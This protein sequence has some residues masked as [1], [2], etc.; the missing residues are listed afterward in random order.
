MLITLCENVYA[1]RWGTS[2][3]NLSGSL[4]SWSVIDKLHTI[5]CPTLVINGID[6]EAQDE[7][8]YPFFEK[9]PKVKWVRFDMSSH[10]P[11]WEERGRYF[12]VVT[13]F[14]NN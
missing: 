7:C 6:D 2:E 8:V 13:G 3:F 4:K 11:F 5:S 1:A 9:I 10:M 14:L 12:E